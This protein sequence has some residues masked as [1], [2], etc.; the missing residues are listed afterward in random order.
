[1]TCM[2]SAELPSTRTYGNTS[3]V[4][5]RVIS[6]GPV[7]LY[8]IIGY[9]NGPAQFVMIFNKTNAPPTNGMTGVFSFPVAASNYFSFDLSYYGANLDAVVVCN[10]T[11]AQT[12]TLG[13]TNCT[14]Q[15]IVG[16]N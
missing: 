1:M 7:K 8:A 2:V 10:S 9:N 13:S 4:P 15:G 3:Y 12:N 5:Y 11:T 16:G 6:K 14:F